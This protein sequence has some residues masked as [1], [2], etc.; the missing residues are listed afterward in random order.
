MSWS[1]LIRFSDGSGRTDFGEPCIEK[2]EDLMSLLE[3]RELHAIR[4]EGD[5]PFSLTR[6]A[7]RVRVERLLGVLRA[8]DVPVIKCIGLN[9]VKHSKFSNDA[10]G[11]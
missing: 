3:R 1:R 10:C 8:E 4:L 2:A 6:T 11:A 5:S 9:Y 7:E